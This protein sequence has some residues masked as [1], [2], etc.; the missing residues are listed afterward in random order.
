MEKSSK[1]ALNPTIPN[2]KNLVT[3]RRHSTP[4]LSPCLIDI[5]SCLFFPN[6][7]KCS[8]GRPPVLVRALPLLEIMWS[9][10]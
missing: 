2:R 10:T 9:N 5:T 4:A 6:I 3:S 7:D 1:V 8:R